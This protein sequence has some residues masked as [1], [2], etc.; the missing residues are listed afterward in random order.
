LVDPFRRKGGTSVCGG[1]G[2]GDRW[3]LAGQERCGF[4]EEAGGKAGAPTSTC[5]AS[6]SESEVEGK[7]VDGNGTKMKTQTTPPLRM[8]SPAFSDPPFG[9]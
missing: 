3:A 4:A 9:W 2:E 1:E 8:A 7:D 5:G 6:F